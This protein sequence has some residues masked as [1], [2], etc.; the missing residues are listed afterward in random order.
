MTF[1]AGT[2]LFRVMDRWVR[3]R[4]SCRPVG[5]SHLRRYLVLTRALGLAYYLLVVFLFARRYRILGARKAGVVPHPTAHGV[6][7]VRML[8]SEP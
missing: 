7:I 1:S 2:L 8:L 5:Q 6:P 3:S 4:C